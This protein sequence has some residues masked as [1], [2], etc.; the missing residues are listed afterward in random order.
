MMHTPA[1]KF[2]GKATPAQTLRDQINRHIGAAFEAWFNK[3]Y[4]VVK[5]TMNSMDY[6]ALQQNLRKAWF[7]SRE[8]M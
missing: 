6:M 1:H 3:E 4:K 7:A 2:T 8:N 5:H